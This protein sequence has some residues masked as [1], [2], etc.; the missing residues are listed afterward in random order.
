MDNKYN[1]YCHTFQGLA[2]RHRGTDQPDP[3]LLMWKDTVEDMDHLLTA[4]SRHTD[5]Y[6]LYIV[7]RGRGRHV[8]EGVSYALARGD[9]YVMGPDTSHYL[10]Q[11]HNLLIQGLYFP[12]A[13]FDAATQDALIEVPGMVSLI[14]GLK[15]DYRGVNRAGRWLHLT[16]DAYEQVAVQLAALNAEWEARRP[17]CGLSLRSL[18]IVLLI[19]LARSKAEVHS[20]PTALKATAH[21][22][23]VTAAIR[24]MEEHYAEELRIEQVAS[25]VFLSRYQFSKMFSEAVGQTPCDFLRHI[26]IERA[27]SLLETTNLSMTVIADQSGLGEPAYFARTFRAVAGMTP[28]EYRRQARKILK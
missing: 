4:I 9:V 13:L 7:Q 3:L 8:I 5:F 24:E 26:R 17:G 28:S 20:R 27:K 11:C 2:Q 22:A 12:L 23:P 1:Y 6:A 18:F 15:G 10:T 16:P 21:T 25:S 19:Q 14:P